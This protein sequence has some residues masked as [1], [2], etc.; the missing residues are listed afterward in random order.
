MIDAKTLIKYKPRGSRANGGLSQYDMDN[1]NDAYYWLFSNRF[2]HVV[3]RNTTTS[4]LHKL[5]EMAKIKA[6][7]QQLINVESDTL[8]AALKLFQNQLNT[9][10]TEKNRVKTS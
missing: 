4:E 6:Q 5:A 3:E 1:V 8:F 7:R 10:K 9:T 2:F